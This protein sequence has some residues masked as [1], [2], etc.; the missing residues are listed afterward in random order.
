MN[1]M[2]LGTLSDEEFMNQPIPEMVDED[3]NSKEEDSSDLDQDSDNDAELDT[4]E[5]DSDD[6]DEDS[7]N[8]DE[9]AENEDEDSSTSGRDSNYEAEG[10]ESSDSTSKEP[11]KNQEGSNGF[12][13]QVLRSF[14][15]NG[16]T[17]TPRNAE[18][19]IRLMQ[20]G[21]NYTKKM[22]VMAPQ[23][24]IM[25]M[26]E[27]HSLLDEDKLAFLIDI[28]NKN[29][30]AIQKFLKDADIDPMD[31][32]VDDESNDSYVAPQGHKVTDREADLKDIAVELSSTPEGQRLIH[33]VDKVWDQESKNQVWDNP[34]ILTD[35]RSHNEA[36][37]YQQV[38]DEIQRQKSLGHLPA[39]VPFL[40]AYKAVGDQLDQQG[41][42][43]HTRVSSTP[44]RPSAVTKGKPKSVANV[45]KGSKAKSAAITRGS[46]KNN[47]AKTIEADMSD[48]DFLKN[49]DSLIS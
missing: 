26:L 46:G 48:D 42:F 49:F 41:A 30:K 36:G 24:K 29:P 6:N 5:Q 21:A 12:E 11:R 25:M 47:I 32:D 40:Q 37:I 19:V 28:N 2:D 14:K 27:R 33:D 9:D 15:A 34:N 18:D 20:M 17:I 22:Q 43:D 31:L 4:D 3:S 13:E 8:E 7:S 23:R 45:E 44:S 38:V 16:E 35:L 10:E 39:T 1:K